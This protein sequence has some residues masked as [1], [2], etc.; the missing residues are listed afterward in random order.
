MLVAVPTFFLLKTAERSFLDAVNEFPMEN[1]KPL[2]IIISKSVAYPDMIKMC[3]YEIKVEPMNNIWCRDGIKEI[4]DDILT[5]VWFD[6]DG[7]VY[8]RGVTL[9]FKHAM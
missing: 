3:A 6:I 7:N 5:R 2:Y 4:G 8:G 1:D 9:V